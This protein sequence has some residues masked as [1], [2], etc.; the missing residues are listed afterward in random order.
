MISPTLIIAMVFIYG[1]IGWTL[2]LSMTNSTLLP[3]HEFVGL[4]QYYKLF[5]NDRWWVAIKNLGIFSVLYVG[6]CIA[7][8]LAL[9]IFLDQKIRME[10]TIRSIYLYPMALS[11]IVT[12]TAWKWMLNPSYG[13]ETVLQNL[14][15]ANASFD[16]LVNPKM[17][18]YTVVI[19]AVWQSSGFVMALFLSGLRGVDEKMIQAA[20]IDGANAWQIYRKIIIPGMSP[21]FFSAIMILTHIAIKSFDLVMALTQ[22]GPGYA[23]EL[24]A[25]FMYTFAFQRSK[26]AMGSASAVMML[27]AVMAIIVPFVYAQTKEPK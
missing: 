11:F 14:G 1:F 18:I 17:A 4:K 23:T 9:A 7:L 25:T 10:N 27:M 26:M 16:W 13:L 22:G 6:M 8:G 12:G 24:P 20:Q 15:F 3:S 19:A 21:V 2:W 5:Q